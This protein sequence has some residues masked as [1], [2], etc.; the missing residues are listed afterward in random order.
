MLVMFEQ[1]VMF[2]QDYGKWFWA[3]SCVL[4]GGWF[5]R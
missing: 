1:G 4:S 2:E 3:E 5:S